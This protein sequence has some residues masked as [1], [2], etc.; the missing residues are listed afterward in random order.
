[1]F[2]PPGRKKILEIF[3]NFPFNEIHL[4]EIARKSNVS[5]SN[6]KNSMQLLVKEGMF[7]KREVSRM[8]F[9]K[10]DLGSDAL[11]KMFEILEME[12]KEKFY[13]K[14][15]KIARLLQN[16]TRDLVNLSNNNIQSVILFGSVARSEWT[17]KSDIDIIA[18]AAEK[19]KNIITALDKAKT[20]LSPLLK[21]T[22][23]SA[24]IENFINGIKNKT[25]FYGELWRDRVVLYNEFLVWQMIKKGSAPSV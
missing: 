11:L 14:N 25:E 7:K 8:S 12:R 21:I 19:D 17:S 13:D 23:I 24:E 6:V 4:R 10:P 18:V 2:I 3:F 15:K 1:M 16:Y 22:P 20:N 9:F 5:L